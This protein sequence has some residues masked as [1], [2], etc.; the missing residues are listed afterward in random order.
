MSLPVFIHDLEGYLNALGTEDAQ[1]R[2]PWAVSV[3]EQITL[4]GAEGR[5][6][7]SVKR[8]KPGETIELIDGVG[9]RAQVE[10]SAV[11]GKEQ[12][13]GVV[14]AYEYQ[15]LP[16][17]QVSVVQALPKSE[18]SELA[19]D[20]L[21]QGGADEILAWQAHR[22]IAK[23]QGAKT[24]KAVLKWQQS[25]IAAAKQSRRAHIPK[26]SGPFSTTEIIDYLS[27]AGR[28]DMVVVLHEEA[29]VAF[30]SLEFGESGRVALII[31]PEGGIT[32]QE[33]EQFHAA[34]AT[35]IKL[36]AEVL[37][38]ASAGMVALAAIGARSSRWS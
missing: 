2:T 3:G 29:T 7:V 24:H 23:W 34:G 26:V 16:A 14:L 33:L 19:V 9:T 13:S 22:C 20:L 27:V 32:D 38:T 30:R 37:R 6:A 15:E 8:I 18:R 12:L 25:A 4:S 35:S 5:H 1:A 11:S 28:F 17:L 36:G 10:V 31:G 21:T